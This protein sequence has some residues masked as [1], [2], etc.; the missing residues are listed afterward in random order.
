MKFEINN[1]GLRNA[2]RQATINWVGQIQPVLDG[3]YESHKGKPVDDVRAALDTAGV[4]DTLHDR[5]S[6]AISSGKRFV[7]EAGEPES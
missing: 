1:E 4:P 6:A 7:L 2:A 3:V 5:A